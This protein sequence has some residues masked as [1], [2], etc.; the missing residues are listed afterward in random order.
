MAVCVLQHA[1]ALGGAGEQ[2]VGVQRRGLL[3]LAAAGLALLS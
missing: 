2:R 3:R 1:A